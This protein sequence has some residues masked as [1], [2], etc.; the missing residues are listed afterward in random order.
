MPVRFDVF[1]SH[2]TPDKPLVEE[3]AR[4]LVRANLKPW[5]D[6]WNLIPGTAWQPEIEAALDACAACAVIIGPG[7]LGPWHHEEMRLAID[8]RVGDR[9]RPFRVIPV[10]LPGVERPERSKLPGFLVATT[11]V[12]FRQTLDDP[13]AF[14]RLVCGIRGVE[15]GAGP[16]GAAFE[17]QNPYRGLELF[18]VAHAPLFFGREALTEW[19][20]DALRR[21]PSG[22]EGRFLAIVGA[23]GSGKSSLARAGLMAAIKDGKLDGSAAWPRAIC[24]PGP[25]P[26]RSLATG[27]TAL[28]PGSIA[29][30]VF[31]R[32]QGRKDGERSLH[33]AAGLVLGEPPRAQRLFV[34]VDQF[35]EVFT[36]CVD[37]AQRRD[38]IANLLHAATVAGGR[39]IVVLTM[40][41]D[42]YPRCAAHADLAA[43]LSDHQVLVGPMTDDELRRAIERPARLAGLE[44][45]PGLVE[46]LVEDVRGRPG[47]LPLL[48]FTL[49]EL[50]RRREAH[51]LT[52]QSYRDIGQIEGAL[53]RT[54]DAVYAGFTP[55]QQELCRRIFLR[56][57]QPGEGSEDTRRRASLREVL[58]ADP[59]QAEAVRAVIGRLAGPET[60]LLTTERGQ[61]AGGEGTLELA[62]EALIRGWPQLR[63]WIETDR[64]G[65]RIHRR[66]TDAAREWESSGRD[67]S[68]LYSGSL[69]AVAEE[70]AGEHPDE[71]SPSEDGFL[72]ASREA[73]DRETRRRRWVQSALLGLGIVAVLVTVAFG[74]LWLRDLQ[75]QNRE[76]RVQ[77]LKDFERWRD[78]VLLR[79][80]G[81]VGVDEAANREAAREA[82]NRA[83]KVIGSAPDP[84]TAVTITPLFS[85]AEREEIVDGCYQILLVLADVLARQ[86]PQEALKI[87]DEAAGLRGRKTHAYYQRRGRYSRILGREA[88]AEE[89]RRADATRSEP[90]E[91]I[92]AFLVGV[93]VFMRNEEQP[94]RGDL[95]AAI[96]HFEQALRA[97]PGYFW[98]SYYLAVCSLKAGRPD[99]AD[100][101]LSACLGQIADR[102]DWDPPRVVVWVYLLRGYARGR[103]DD[104]RAAEDDFRRVDERLHRDDRED[105]QLEADARYALFVDRGAI[106]LRQG[107]LAAALADF[108]QAARSEPKRYQAYVNLALLFKRQGRFPEALAQ[109][110]RATQFHPPRPVR[111]DFQADRADILLLSGQYQRALDECNALLESC[112]DETAAYNVKALALAKLGDFRKAACSFTQYLERG[113]TPT[114][115]LY[116]RRGV[117][118]MEAGDYRGAVDDFSEVLRQGHAP[119]RESLIH[120]GWAHFFAEEFKSALSDFEAAIRLEPRQAEG[121]IGRGLARVSLARCREGIADAEEARRL[122]PESPEPHL[123]FNLACIFGRAAGLA[124]ADAKP[125]E[126]PSLVAR[127]RDRAVEALAQALDRTPAAEQPAL[128]SKIR[129]DPYLAPVRDSPEFRA[130][131]TRRAGAPP[132]PAP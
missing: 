68:Y 122:L 28:A 32:L 46:L 47:A 93:D 21:Q 17:G 40:R 12:E 5:L 4:R 105:G 23:S 118:R 50:C 39:T 31:D 37:E 114:R 92:D 87:L 29:P 124:E 38:L 6:T 63:Q 127:A 120:L 76:L 67:R 45:E 69:L 48:Q 77:A 71:L 79:G 60:R 61:P 132:R 66:L 91:A 27:L 116:E 88:A 9:Q 100:A 83:L 70:W 111:E 58:P 98:A 131:E 36:T 96:G 51:R 24:R 16:G 86:S 59:A 56:L 113:G 2:A 80:S 99:V 89:R 123:L 33:V 126:A 84:G 104:Y 3:L 90:P 54:A 119:D 43:A 35:E 30:V 41:A 73:R 130:L 1:L 25:E 62:H 22:A 107:Q 65:L 74:L 20:L 10:L 55:A 19:L 82:A 94:T 112:P 110:D 7:G 101:Y 52:I 106:R 97:K 78:E 117:A 53:Q 42:F 57:V 72:R 64:A 11:W 34:L 125:T 44:P 15:P 129:T 13:E 109:L 95:S 75:L 26:F 18:D 8:Q 49:Q 14:H 103:Q 115:D 102:L 85:G 108:E 128:W 81:P 121:Y